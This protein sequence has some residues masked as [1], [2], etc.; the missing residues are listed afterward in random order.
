MKDLPVDVTARAIRGARLV[1]ITR[2]DGVIRRIAE[3]QQVISVDSNDEYMPVPGVE[4]SAIKSAVG[5]DTSSIQ[6]IAAHSVGGYF[7]TEDIDI[8]LYDG[9]EVTVYV[10]DR[11]NP[12]ETGFMFYGTIQPIQYDT[13]GR[14]SFDVR[15]P[16]IAANVSYIEKFSPMCRV[17][18]FSTRCGLDPTSFEESAVVATIVNRHKFTVTIGSPPD[19]GY[20]NGGVCLT[21]SG[22]RFVVADWQQSTA[23]ITA[24][25]PCNRMLFVGEGLTLWPGCDKR[26]ATCRDKF[27]NT[28]NFQGEPHS[29]GIYQIIAGG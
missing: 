6:I 12:S 1:E 17:D 4:I 16:S 3:A 21:E 10:V 5:G 2:R 25:L 24:F 20:F 9:A 23:M 19:T 8:G 7:N 29:L 26:I 27:S 14:V 18:L 15:G 11:D 22:K 13:S 28:I